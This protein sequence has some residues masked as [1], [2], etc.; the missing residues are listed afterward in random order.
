MGYCELCGKED[1]LHKSL[2]EGVVLKV[3]SNCS[4][5]GRIIEEKKMQYTK[6]TNI[7][8]VED[9][10]VENFGNLIKSAREKRS[11]TQKELAD[12]IKER[13]SMISK[14]EKNELKPDVN[15]ARK[16]EKFI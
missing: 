3:C 16:F 1:D 2:V 15:T 7:Y 13:E 11:M 14:I 5:F 9:N 8:E 6:I 4:G 12:K 10:I